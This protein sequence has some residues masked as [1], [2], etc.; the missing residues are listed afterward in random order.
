MD[1]EANKMKRNRRIEMIGITGN[2]VWWRSKCDDKYTI[3]NRRD[4]GV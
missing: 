2:K 4:K 1:K 3:K